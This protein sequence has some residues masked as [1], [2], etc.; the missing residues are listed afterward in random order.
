[1]KSFFKIFQVCTFLRKRNVEESI[2][3][4]F[5][6]NKVSKWYFLNCNVAKL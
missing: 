6:K 1:M 2:I 3:Q 5:W 4:N